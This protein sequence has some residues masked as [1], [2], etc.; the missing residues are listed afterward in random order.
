MPQ[1]WLF[2]LEGRQRT[3]DGCARR[4]ANR[5]CIAR[6][7]GGETGVCFSNANRE[8]TFEF[9]IRGV[10][11]YNR[12]VNVGDSVGKI[13]NSIYVYSLDVHLRGYKQIHW[14]INAA[15]MRPIAGMSAGQHS[16]VKIGVHLYYE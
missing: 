12:E 5:S 6:L 4:N 16:G 10:S 7:Q 8:P 3:R 11:D 13:R 15:V 2:N 1:L 14:P 9:S